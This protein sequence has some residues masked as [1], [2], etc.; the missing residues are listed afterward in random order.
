MSSVW[1]GYL[2]L[3][4]LMVTTLFGGSAASAASQDEFDALFSAHM[5]STKKAYMSF[6]EA[7]PTSAFAPEVFDII[8]NTFAAPAAPPP[9]AP[10]PTPALPTQVSPQTQSFQY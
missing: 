4:A 10:P 7:Y 9:V 5:L 6:L 3:R 2:I 8:A 1:R